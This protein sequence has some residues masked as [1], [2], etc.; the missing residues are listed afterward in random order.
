MRRIRAAI[1]ETARDANS[2]ARL[3]LRVQTAAG[4]V[5]T[6]SPSKPRE[7]QFPAYPHFTPWAA[8]G[9]RARDP[10]SD[11]HRLSLTSWVPIPRQFAVEAFKPPGRVI[12][13]G[14]ATGRRCGTMSTQPSFL[15]WKVLY[16]AG[17][18]IEA[19]ALRVRTIR[20]LFR[21]Q[22]RDLGV[23]G[24]E[25]RLDP[26][27]RQRL[28]RPPDHAGSQAQESSPD[29]GRPT[30]GTNRSPGGATRSPVAKLRYR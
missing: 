3:P 28:H 14:G 6:E 1:G 8:G 19:D 11:C 7:L 16:T 13:L 30:G 5:G 24:Y 15:S 20:P 26:L 22:M 27:R 29:S 2:A 9:K 23:D 4:H 17:T 12:G 18:L 10:A 25:H 21:A